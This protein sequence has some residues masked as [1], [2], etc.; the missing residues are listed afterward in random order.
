MVTIFMSLV[1]HGLLIVRIFVCH[2]LLIRGCMILKLAILREGQWDSDVLNTL[3]SHEL[4]DAI[5][6]ISVSKNRGKDRLMASTTSGILNVKSVY[7]IAQN[8]LGNLSP[9]R[10]HR[11]CIW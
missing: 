7:L 8:I 11:R 9:D 5:C 2:N 3:F 4:V 1:T 10:S 6:R